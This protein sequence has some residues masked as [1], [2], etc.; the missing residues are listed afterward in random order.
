[1][2]T[3]AERV[4]F[5][6]RSL[7][8][9]YG[10]RQYKMSKFEEYD[11]YARNKDFLIG[12]SVITFTDTDGKLLALKPD[13]TLSIVKN[14]KDCPGVQK[15]YY[16]EN[17]YRVTK[18]AHG[19]REIMQVG[20]ECLGDIDEYC[21]CEVLVLAAE[22]LSRISG[23]SVLVISHLG[24]IS[25]LMSSLEIPQEKRAELLHLIGE[26]NPHGL[27]GLCR[28][29]GLDPAQTE[30]LCTLASLSG[31]PR[32]LLPKLEEM[33]GGYV[34][35]ETLR[36]FRTVIDALCGFGTKTALRIDLSMVDDL[37]YYNGIVFKGFISGLPGCVLTGGQ[38]DPVMRKLNRRGGAVGFA[39]YT[40]M[41]EM[42]EQSSGDFDVD[43]VLLYDD[44]TPL[45]Q[46]CLQAQA[47]GGGVLLQRSLPEDI[48]YRRLMKITNGEVECLETNA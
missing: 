15:L 40:D 37:R 47:L 41:L 28:E 12:D 6:L 7:Y 18:G 33:L 27:T 13:V 3:S 10:Y 38:Y 25:E 35:P 1:M 19:F 48:R 29:L 45:S 21:I 14:H 11:L 5:M 26:K 16:N 44:T 20:L 34:A 39:V 17:V 46:L 31:E 43:T 24:L 8:D 36:S 23:D 2:L 4:A 22:S 42:L 32:Q 30:L 9:N